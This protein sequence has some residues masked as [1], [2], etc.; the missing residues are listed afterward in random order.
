[1]EVV[2]RRVAVVIGPQQVGQALTMQAALGSEGQELDQ[3]LG[4]AQAPG[5]LLD[6]TIVRGDREAPQ[7]THARYRVIHPRASVDDPTVSW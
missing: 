1:V 4:L 7:Q 3:R 6:H 2:D 5:A